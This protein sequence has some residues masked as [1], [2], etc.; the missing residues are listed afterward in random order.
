M[1]YVFYLSRQHISAQEHV[2]VA[3]VEHA[4]LGVRQPHEV[5]S[6]QHEG[7]HGL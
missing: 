7:L 6:L 4:E 1:Q 3:A 2:A 5:A